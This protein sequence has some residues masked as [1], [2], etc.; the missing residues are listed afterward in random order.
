METYRVWF[1]MEG[2]V[3]IEAESE[4]EARERFGQKSDSELQENVLGS[5]FIDDV[6]KP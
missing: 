1:T 4:E 6:C 2:F 3:D 5:A